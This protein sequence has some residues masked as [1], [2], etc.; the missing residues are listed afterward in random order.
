M[1][2]T[3]KTDRTD[4]VLTLSKVA[5]KAAIQIDYI[6]KEMSKLD[7]KEKKELILKDM[8]PGMYCFKVKQTWNCKMKII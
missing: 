1:E 2:T 3:W 8:Q 4:I 5:D 6:S 7:I